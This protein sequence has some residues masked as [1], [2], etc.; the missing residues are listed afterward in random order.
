MTN[1]DVIGTFMAAYLNS[2]TAGYSNIQPSVNYIMAFMIVLTIT[3]TAL[4]TWVWGE[5]ESMIRGLISRILLIGFI[6]L[7]VQN[8]EK[9]SDM[10]GIGLTQ[11][12]LKASGSGASATS[13]L[14]NPVSIAH[15]G[16][17]LFKQLLAAANQYPTGVTGLGNFTNILLYGI[18]GLVVFLAYAVIALQVFVTF[19]EF[20]L[21]NL[22]A[23]VFVPFAVWQRTSFLSDRAF[24]YIFSAGIKLFVLALVVSI[25]VNFTTQFTVSPTP[26]FENA[27][28]ILTGSLMLMALAIFV[29]RLAQALVTGGPQLGAGEA[30]MG[31]GAAAAIVGGG[32]YFATRGVAA[33][34]GA[35]TSRAFGGT[36]GDAVAAYRAAAFAGT[37]SQTGGGPGGSQGGGGGQQGGSSGRMAKAAAAGAGRAFQPGGGGGISSTQPSNPSEED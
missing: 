12:G 20:K 4:L 7:L 34:S 10:V 33:A 30:A 14:Q 22:A 36:A 16:F 8:W 5:W 15:T 11:L 27:L 25:G 26:D 37:G 18:A 9:Y 21:I 2:I 32:A 23:L 19:L 24:G 35:L 1:F 28:A 6:L 17:V 3:L 29:P 31:A 13:F